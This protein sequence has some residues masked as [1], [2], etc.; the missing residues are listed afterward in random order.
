LIIRLFICIAVVIS[1][2]GIALIDN[3][4]AVNILLIKSQYRF[5]F[6]LLS[7]YFS[8]ELTLD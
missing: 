8:I 6:N 5:I 7:N 2:I 4:H 1:F 3:L